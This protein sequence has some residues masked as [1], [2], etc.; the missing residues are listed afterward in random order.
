MAQKSDY[1]TI[2]EYKEI[3]KSNYSGLSTGQRNPLNDMDTPA[4]IRNRINLGKK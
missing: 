2:N 4:Y 3:E 1:V